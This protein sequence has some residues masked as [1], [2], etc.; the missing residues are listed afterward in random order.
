MA[1]HGQILGRDP[2]RRGAPETSDRTDAAVLFAG[3]WAVAALFHVLSAPQR[4]VAFP[5]PNAEG[6]AALGVAVAATGVLVRPRDARWLVAL[7]VLQLGSVWVEAPMLGNHWFIGGAVALTIL[8]AAASVRRRTGRV[9][10]APLYAAFGPVARWVLLV[11][12]VFA[13][14]AKLNRGFLDPDVSCAVFFLRETA[15]AAGLGGTIDRAPPELL[16]AAIGATVVIELAVPVLLIVR[17]T[18]ASGVL[19]AVAFHTVLGLDL[20]HPFFD[21]STLLF[22]LFALFLPPDF[23]PWLHGR[24]QRD[25][26]HR[27]RASPLL[28]GASRAALALVLLA[29]VGPA[30]PRLAVVVIATAYLAWFGYAVAAIVAVATY[31]VRQRPRGARGILRPTVP[32][33]AL[34]VPLVLLNGL[35]PYLELK[36]ASGFTM[37]SNLTTVDGRTNHLLMPRTLPLTDAHDQLVVIRSS[38]DAG[39]QWYADHG[40]A[41]PRPTFRSY[42]ADHPDVTVAY[43]QDGAPRRYG[44]GMEPPPPPPMWREKLQPFRAVDLQD[45]PRCQDRWG[46]AN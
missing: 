24:L 45:P 42:L 33:A 39:L 27:R 10:P 46:P 30:S 11:S 21:F 23:A 22:A 12:Y 18:R 5:V 34:V 9:E 14:F 3:L 6:L 7:A 37:Y 38:D 31:V 15:G 32:A 44:P 41:L 16:T 20:A 26:D 28:V 43:L 40:Y 36:T 19:L 13:A 4:F 8:L 2:V 25:G 1:S 17:R 35:T 29:A